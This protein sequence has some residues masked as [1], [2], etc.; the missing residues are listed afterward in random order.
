MDGGREARL[1][2][3]ESMSVLHQGSGEKVSLT[4]QQP[5][6]EGEKFNQLQTHKRAL[7]PERE[8][9]LCVS[10]GVEPRKVDTDERGRECN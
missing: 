5:Q 6:Q 4:V 10:S 8:R 2:V 9:S 7:D 1:C 3:Q